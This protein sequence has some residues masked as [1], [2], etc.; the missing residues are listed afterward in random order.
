MTSLAYLAVCFFIGFTFSIS[1]KS[2]SELTPEEC[3]TCDN[4]QKQFAGIFHCCTDSLGL[5]KDEKIRS[6]YRDCCN[7]CKPAF[8]ACKVEFEH[9]RETWAHCKWLAQDCPESCK[10][11][12]TEEKH[13]VVRRK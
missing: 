10:K 4:D 6:W 8:A 11:I 3:R 2:V 7:S 9:Q 13:L 1:A 5:H 12:V